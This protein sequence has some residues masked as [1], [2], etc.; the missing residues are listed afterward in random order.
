MN[1]FCDF[2]EKKRNQRNTHLRR[3]LCYPGRKK[4]ERELSKS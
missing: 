1:M 2:K 4:E 3:K